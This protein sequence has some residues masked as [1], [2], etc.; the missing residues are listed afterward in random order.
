MTLSF[1]P[2]THGPKVGYLFPG[3]GA[4]AVGM[5]R[6]LYNESPAARSDSLALAVGALWIWSIL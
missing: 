1:M 4:Q 2:E 3:Q 5:G 6:Q